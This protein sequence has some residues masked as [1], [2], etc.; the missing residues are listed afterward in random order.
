MIE[1]DFKVGELLEPTGA[2]FQILPEL[3]VRTR[4]RLSELLLKFTSNGLEAAKRHLQR[5]QVLLTHQPPSDVVLSRKLLLRVYHLLGVVYE[6][7]N[8]L[9]LCK[10]I[11]QKGIQQS[12]AW[13]ELS[14]WYSFSLQLANVGFQ[15]ASPNSDSS[16]L[17]ILTFSE[18]LNHP[19]F[20]QLVFLLAKLQVLMALEDTRIST[21]LQNCLKLFCHI[22]DSGQLNPL[23]LKHFH[24]H[25]S[26]LQ[27]SHLASRGQFVECNNFVSNIVA[28]Q[29]QLEQSNAKELDQTYVWL[30]GP[31]V[32]STIY[33]IA[34]IVYRPSQPGVSLAH[35]LK[36]LDFVSSHSQRHAVSTVR[37]IKPHSRP[38]L[39]KLK[40]ALLECITSLY[41][42][43]THLRE[44]L[45]VCV[46]VAQFY[47]RNR[48]EFHDAQFCAVHILLW[49]YAMAVGQPL[50]AKQH[51]QQAFSQAE[52]KGKSD[53]LYLLCCVYTSL[54][55]LCLNSFTEA[56]TILAEKEND[57]RHHS[58]TTV[59]A[60]L[61]F[62]KGHLLSLGRESLA[63][64]SE[65]L[66]LADTQLC[67]KQLTVQSLR[68]LAE[69][70][71]VTGNFA[72]GKQML[73]TALLLARELEDLASILHCTSLYHVLYSKLGDVNGMTNIIEYSSRKLHEFSQE[74]NSSQHSPEYRLLQ[75]ALSLPQPT[76]PAC[77]PFDMISDSILASA[78]NE[79]A[80][81]VLANH[82]SSE[83]QP[84]M[85]DSFNSAFSS[86]S[87]DQYTFI[88]S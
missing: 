5:A 52:K 55:C 9:R 18:D 63:K 26:I 11:L 7:V 40:F 80:L 15:C 48:S 49:V 1:A 13:R 12:C 67:N 61:L 58:C 86:C 59:R 62:L 54:T 38:F 71:I 88:D 32:W 73:D 65:C 84:G 2:R 51:I 44:G 35:A 47:Y 34:S 69:G 64:F 20:V 21:C 56:R 81:D 33:L 70:Y 10:Q 68:F 72:G 78:R 4:V 22:R 76:L 27:V 87:I 42:T 60:L 66:A 37:F 30:T 41:F 75:D 77:Q 31:E 17:K 57:L 36:G 39:L 16:L 8:K 53:R 14:W 45:G 25:L 19:S 23:L 3:E 46:K 79:Q 82:A 43:K 6:G 85:A 29:Q 24:L 28:L 83:N 74:V 50:L